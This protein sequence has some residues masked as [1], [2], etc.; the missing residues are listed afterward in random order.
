MNKSS[1]KHIQ[2]IHKCFGVQHLEAFCWS[3]DHIWCIDPEAGLVFLKVMF[4]V[5]YVTCLRISIQFEFW[6]MQEFISISSRLSNSN[7]SKVFLAHFFFFFFFFLADSQ[8]I[9][10]IFLPATKKQ[11]QKLGLWHKAMQQKWVNMLMREVLWDKSFFFL[12]LIIHL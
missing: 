11:K 12:G 3:L 10:K 5:T 7:F 6:L 2:F 1:C 4:L 9:F 8:P